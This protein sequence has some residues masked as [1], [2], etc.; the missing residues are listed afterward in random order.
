MLFE[1]LKDKMIAHN[2]VH[3]WYISVKLHFFLLKILFQI[4]SITGQDVLACNK[5]IQ[6]SD[7][8]K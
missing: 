5:Q 1:W 2:S 3:C 6:L 8:I 7:D 4:Q